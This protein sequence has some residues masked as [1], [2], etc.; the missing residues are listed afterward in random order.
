MSSHSSAAGFFAGMRDIAPLAFGVA[1]YGLAFGLLAAEAGFAPL[2]IGVMALV[3]Y[4]GSSQIVAT[5]QWLAGA[6]V[7]ASVL[8]GL[9][10]NLR[11]LLMT[12]SIRDLFAGQPLWKTA[13]GAHMTADENWALLMAARAR[14]REVGYAYL[15]GAGLTQMAAWCASTVLGVVFAAVIPE[16]KALGMDFAFT[17][18]FIAIARSLWR[19]RPDLLPWLV[20]VA[21]V[22]GGVKLAGAP[23]HWMLALGG[24]LGAAVAGARRDG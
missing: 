5:Q 18:A 1:V 22:F 21:V 15:I 6:G 3:V 24:L 19:G 12:A 8:A 10:L 16:P 23:S 9:A 17:A 2:Q 7:A 13:F 20:S 11:I 14:G 4:A